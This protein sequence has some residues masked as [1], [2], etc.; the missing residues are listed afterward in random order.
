M[1]K[2]NAVLKAKSRKKAESARVGRP[3][4]GGSDPSFTLRLPDPVRTAL[5]KQARKLGIKVGAHA[6]AVLEKQAAIR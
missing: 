4:S 2:R 1:K 3:A 6:R 5:E